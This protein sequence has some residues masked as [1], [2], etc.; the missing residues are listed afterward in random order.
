MLTTKTL[1]DYDSDKLGKLDQQ[2]YDYEMENYEILKNRA[3][4]YGFKILFHNP[5]KPHLWKRT[6]EQGIDKKL[7]VKTRDGIPYMFYIEESYQ[8]H[9][10]YYRKAWF[11]KCR[12][13]RF[14]NVPRSRFNIRIILTNKPSNMYGIRPIA[15]K[16]G[17]RHI[18]NMS[19]LID[20]INRI[21]N[22]NF[23]SHIH[24]TNIIPNNSI[25]STSNRTTNNVYAYSE[26][27]INKELIE[28][29]KWLDEPVKPLYVMWLRYKVDVEEDN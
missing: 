25:V 27:N 14:R 18:F 8:S 21:R 11:E 9:E 4:E 19:A 22:L 5:E 7:E 28:Y 16:H 1:D 24:N 17:I 26:E 6:K 13:P 3:K 29:R 2:G 20:Y 10:Y 23:Y 15:K 12:V